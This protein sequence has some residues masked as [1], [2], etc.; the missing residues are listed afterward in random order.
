VPEPQLTLE[1]PATAIQDLI[2]AEQPLSLDR[3]K[4]LIDPSRKGRALA[5]AASKEFAFAAMNTTGAHTQMSV[6][7]RSVVVLRGS[8]GAAILHDIVVPKDDAA[9]SVWTASELADSLRLHRVL[10]TGDGG[11]GET[12]FLNVI[13]PNQ[14]AIQDISS[15]D[16][17]GVVLNDWAVLFY[18]EPRSAT[19]AVSFLVDG[20]QKLNVLVTGL[21][22]GDWEVWR[23]GW[24]LDVP[25]G[26]APS[27]G[28]LFFEG[29]A[30]SYFLR[31]RP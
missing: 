8:V 2:A 22:P 12:A 27:A 31:R 24:L 21:A 5:F 7:Q 17:A 13:A 26:V 30:G 28:S 14:T 16:L 25:G 15:L 18:T 6:V 19:A 23:D 1:V 3:L 9:R 10:P 29:R 4:T 11:V 20:K